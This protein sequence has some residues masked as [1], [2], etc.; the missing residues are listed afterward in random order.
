MTNE[1]IKD[2]AT[3]ESTLQ[4]IF[5][6]AFSFV[7]FTLPI[8]YGS[9]WLSGNLP[10]YPESFLYSAFPTSTLNL[11]SAIMLILAFI[12]FK[13]KA[14][15]KGMGLIILS[16][17][18]IALTCA[19]FGN[20]PKDMEFY[21]NSINQM[22]TTLFML[23]IAAICISTNK[24]AKSFIIAGICCGLIYTILNGLYQYLWGF[25]DTRAFYEAQIAQGAQFPAQQKSRIMQTL[26]YSTFTISNSFAAHIILTAPILYYG[27]KKYFNAENPQAVKVGSLAMIIYGC[28]AAFSASNLILGVVC[29][30]I[31]IIFFLKAQELPKAAYD[32]AGGLLL[33]IT[34]IVLFLTRS[35]AG[36]ACFV[37]GV[38]LAFTLTAKDKKQRT[39]GIGFLSIGSIIACFIAPRV[40]SFQ[41][42]LGYY[43]TMVD[44]FMKDVFGAGFGSFSSSYNKYKDAGIEESNVPHSFF[45]GYLGQGGLFCGLAVILCFVLTIY[46]IVRSKASRRL[47]FLLLAGFCS[48]FLHAQLDFNIMIIGTLSTAAIIGLI[49]FTDDSSQVNFKV[50]TFTLFPIVLLAIFFNIS[51]LKAERSYYY[52]YQELNAQE[53]PS[54]DEVE[55]ITS[56]ISNRTTFSSNH[57]TESAQWAMS[58]YFSRPGLN[59]IQRFEYLNF[60]ATSLQ[61]AARLTPEKTAIHISLA[62]AY[63][64]QKNYKLAF[65]ALNTAFETYPFSP[66][67]TKLEQQLLFEL[68]G[69]HPRDPELRLRFLNNKIRQLKTYLGQLRFITHLNLSQK[70]KNSIITNLEKAAVE[71]YFEIDK[72]KKISIKLDFNEISKQVA[73]VVND[74]KELK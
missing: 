16:W 65:Q 54:L 14:I 5:L 31:G 70:E 60:A 39:L 68:I 57:L 66:T 12:I 37:A 26:V 72:L 34:I 25:A 44:S 47:K 7:M 59:E 18:S 29:A 2:T 58:Q 64:F 22:V 52:L 41:V 56:K 73:D 6:Y 38:T 43:A 17:A 19:A 48:W 10:I 62:R 27:W 45:F 53:Q 36:I 28:S 74:A 40:G 46:A 32:Y 63:I 13:P 20:Y 23:F 69:R 61:S 67:A 1:G 8:K 35:R 42:R 9:S 21:L 30:L 33:V 49:A 15:N 3:K 55:N 50:A 11:L 71:I 4:T 24:K 51:K